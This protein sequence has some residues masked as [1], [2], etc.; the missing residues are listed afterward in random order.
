VTVDV[1]TERKVA[2]ANLEVAERAMKLASDDPAA[3]KV[4]KQ[5]RQAALENLERLDWA[6][7]HQAEVAREAEARQAEGALAE[8]QARARAAQ[9]RGRELAVSVAPLVDRLEGVVLELQ[10][11][12]QQV[13]RGILFEQDASLK[14]MIARP[15]I[16]TG[17]GV[18]AELAV[19]LLRAARELVKL[20]PVTMQ[21]AETRAIQ[22]RLQRTEKADA[23]AR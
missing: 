4:A 9:Q 3:F 16:T 11:C 18:E 17:V 13:N 1:G 21:I 6:E 22:G 14:R 8:A 12:S 20:S 2:R 7:K 5:E 23:D 19:R 10:E 15:T